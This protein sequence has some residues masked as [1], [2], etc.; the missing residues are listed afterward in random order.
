VTG[1]AQE[2]LFMESGARRQ[3]EGILWKSDAGEIV[4]RSAALKRVLELVQLV[5]RTDA[6]ALIL[7]ETG[8][9]K[10]LIAMA[11]HQMSSR[12]NHSLV[13]TSCTAIPA[14]LL[15]NELFGHERGSFTGAVS[16]TIGRFELAS[17]GTLFLDEIGDIPLEL[18]P[19][20]LRALQEHEIERIGSARAIQVDVRIVAATH[21]DLAQMVQRGRFRSDLYYRL[22]IFPIE[23][24]P[25][26]ERKEDIP[27][28]ARHFARKYGNEMN[29]QIPTISEGDM[30][31]L[32][33][34]SWPGNIRELQNT[35]ERSVIMTFGTVLELTPMA[36]PRSDASQNAP[37]SLT[38]DDAER[39]HILQA[40]RETDGVIGGPGG[41]AAL[42]GVKRTTLL[43]KM[44]RLGISRP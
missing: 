33:D 44:K 21:R 2:R 12:R 10:E 27:L 8:T 43:Y 26:R 35:M 3:E 34:Y 24:P 22:C 39:K 6:T 15:E 30:D 28:L 32:C 23:I 31:V 29:R 42:L 7:G 9:G 5:A 13:K 14:G 1:A 36:G 16:Q 25:L 41:A 4:G 17:K 38:L 11:I 18:Q 19:K 37:E 20:F 40:L